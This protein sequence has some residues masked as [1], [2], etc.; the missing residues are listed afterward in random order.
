M[1][2]RD[3]LAKSW[4]PRRRPALFRSICDRSSS[5]RSGIGFRVV[6]VSGRISRHDRVAS[7]P[8]AAIGRGSPAGARGCASPFGGRRS[9][10]PDQTIG[11]R[12]AFS[13]RE[14]PPIQ[15]GL[16]QEDKLETGSPQDSTPFSSNEPPLLPLRTSSWPSVSRRC[17]CHGRSNP[18]AGQPR[19]QR[20]PIDRRL[21]HL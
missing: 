20:R 7:S 11:P 16:P 21:R 8:G 10:S 15:T 13:R 14:P 19:E 4:W 2:I 18:A 5:D 3:P 12:S 6:A 17:C 1:T 9:E